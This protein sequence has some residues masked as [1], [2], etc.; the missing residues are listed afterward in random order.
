LLATTGNGL[1]TEIKSMAG[2]VQ[3]GTVS[4]DPGSKSGGSSLGRV[5]VIATLLA[6]GALALFQLGKADLDTDEGRYGISALNILYD[7]H[8]IA[9]VSP[10]PGGVP[11][12]TWPYMYPLEL[13]G[14]IVLLGKTEFALRVVNVLLMLL[15]AEPP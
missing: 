15:T 12:S 4:L 10:E 11:W 7:Y 1:T 14:S 13:A 3:L 9:I 5:A 6:Y 8:Q 2:S